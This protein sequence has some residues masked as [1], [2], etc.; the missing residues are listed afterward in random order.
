MNFLIT[1]L[2]VVVALVSAV[3]LI[4]FLVAVRKRW[5]SRFREGQFLTTLLALVG[6]VLCSSCLIAVWGYE[7]SEKL[8]RQSIS[9]ELGEFSELVAE[10]SKRELKLASERLLA[11]AGYSVR[12]WK[13]T[14]LTEHLQELGTAFYGVPS[15]CHF[16]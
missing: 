15:T 5:L 7:V 12:R 16:R 4:V 14:D 10:E 13:N 6:A 8:F 3:S 1:P 9:Q 2:V 11:A